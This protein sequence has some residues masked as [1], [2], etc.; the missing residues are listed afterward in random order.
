MQEPAGVSGGRP[1]HGPRSTLWMLRQVSMRLC[2]SWPYD[3]APL[4][5]CCGIAAC[6]ALV[7]RPIDC[8]LSQSGVCCSV[9]SRSVELAIPNLRE[10]AG[11]LQPELENDLDDSRR[12]SEGK[13]E[14]E[15]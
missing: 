8:V 4:D 1:S 9:C 12:H 11:L 14:R 15:S 3:A 10:G 13:K 2:L 5:Y 6:V 7:R